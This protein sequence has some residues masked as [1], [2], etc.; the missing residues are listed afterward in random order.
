[1][2]PQAL[3]PVLA[4]TPAPTD[5][6]DDGE[7]RIPDFPGE[8]PTN[9]EL[10]D[11]LDAVLPTVRQT[12]GA[13]L[14]GDTP[15]HLVELT[16]GP[17]DLTGYSRITA[18][19]TA[20][21]SMTA[22][23]VA[24]HNRK[25]A[26]AEASKAQ[27]EAKLKQGLRE[28]KNGLAQWLESVMRRHASLRLQ[29]LKA[30]HADGQYHD[31]AA[32]MLELIAL[33]GTTGVLEETRDHDREVERMRDE[34]LP[35]GCATREF[36]DKI[37]RL[38][39]DHK[40]HL[41]RPFA[42]D[43]AF[44]QFVIKLMPRANA[45][46]GRALVKELRSAGTLGDLSVVIRRTTEIVHESQSPASRA[47]GAAVPTAAAAPAA[48]TGATG[49][50]VQSIVAAV[51]TALSAAGVA[52]ASEKKTTAAEKKAAAAAAATAA[53]AAAAAKSTKKTRIGKLPEGQWCWSNTCQYDHPKPTVCYRAPWTKLS[54]L[55][56]NLQTNAAALA[57][58]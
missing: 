6:R 46:E 29:R 1:M 8:Q 34:F 26:E 16:L 13:V 33:R 38:V 27:R 35:D 51:L 22:G 24:A 37:E 36:T 25:V 52:P 19:S 55:P 41:E 44:S 31:G 57:A 2:F 14:N 30:A 21:G 20:A 32:M 17:D 9:K 7:K 45:A 3:W 48:P 4:A 54:E 11:W 23:Q 50:S 43:E 40:P 58:R 15:A 47:A 10:S 53:A 56:A 18:G 39:R 28:H 49:A 42:S 5:G 12:H